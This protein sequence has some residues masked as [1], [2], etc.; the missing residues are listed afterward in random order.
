MRDRRTPCKLPSYRRSRPE[1]EA[2]LNP[3]NM[4]NS[5]LIEAVCHRLEAKQKNKFWLNR[6][7]KN[8]IR[9]L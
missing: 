6:F 3:F 7:N 5:D 2:L 8:I 9:W 1:V 4:L